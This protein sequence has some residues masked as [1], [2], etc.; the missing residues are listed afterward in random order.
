[1]TTSNNT[2]IHSL[3]WLRGVM[4]LSIMLY[5]YGVWMDVSHVLN[6]LGIYAVSIFFVLSGLSMGIVYGKSIFYKETI[7]SFFFRRI[8]RIWPLLWL[9]VALVVIPTV[10]LG[11]GPYNHE[12]YQLKQI[13]LNITTL[14]G[15]FND[16]GYINVGAWSLGNEMFY[17]LFTPLL[18]YIFQ[19]RK[20]IGNYLTIFSF[21]IGVYFSFIILDKDKSLAI[22]FKVYTNP[23]NNFFFYLCGLAIYYNF[24]GYKPSM[25]ISK[26]LPLLAII[27]FIFYPVQGDQIVIV[28]GWNRIYFSFVS[29]FIVF[30]FFVSP[31]KVPK[32]VALS[33]TF[34]GL[35]SFGI[36]LL[37]PI[38]AWYIDGVFDFIESIFLIHKLPYVRTLFSLIFTLFLSLITYKYFETPFILFAKRKLIGK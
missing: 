1:M 30:V 7:Y 23:L 27:L 38:I 6:R 20:K 13:I 2:R 24:K 33:L 26:S 29:I 18:I 16:G 21:L 11:R 37:H 36:Y 8:V 5:H 4:S 31:P 10:I 17:Y 34:L 14:A 19:K 15:Y 28:T 3:D 9:A 22:Q 12:P 35:A 25:Y 32:L